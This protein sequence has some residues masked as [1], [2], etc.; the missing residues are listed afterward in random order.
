MEAPIDSSGS[1]IEISRDQSEIASRAVE[2]ERLETGVW[3][4]EGLKEN[5][6]KREKRYVLSIDL[7]EVIVV[8]GIQARVRRLIESKA[9]V[10]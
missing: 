8:E 7:R 4:M 9:T 6:L 10:N 5:V 3:A 1:L 2:R